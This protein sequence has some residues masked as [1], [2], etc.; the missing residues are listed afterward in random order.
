MTTRAELIEQGVLRREE[1]IRFTRAYQE[2]YG[3]PPSMQE[4]ADGVGIRKN[5]VRHHLIKLREDGRVTMVQGKY[6]SLRVVDA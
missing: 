5:A 3:F 2:E 4:I 6:R 1:I